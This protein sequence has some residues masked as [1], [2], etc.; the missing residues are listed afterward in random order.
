MT[1]T[2]DRDTLRLG[3]YD[4]RTSYSEQISILPPGD[5]KVTFE[6]LDE[7][8][9]FNC[10]RTS[11]IVFPDC[12]SV[13][14]NNCGAD[15]FEILANDPYCLYLDY[16]GREWLGS[17][18][19]LEDRA[20]YDDLPINC[21]VYGGLYTYEEALTI[22]PIGWR[23][24]TLPTKQE[25]QELL[26]MGSADVTISGEKTIIPGAYF[27]KDNNYWGIQNSGEPGFNVKPSGYQTP[28]GGFSHLGR[29]AYFWSATESEDPENANAM[30][31]IFSD[32]NNNVIISPNLKTNKM[33]CRCIKN[34]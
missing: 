17:N 1:L 22:C 5:Y 15:G 9:N 27:F 24:P 11:S 7:T 32:T 18:L 23:L 34:D 33:S 6:Y 10:I 8:G 3:P 19:R 2:S 14:D 4:F 28:T 31:V 21:E 16:L 13:N 26:E 20:C 29:Y 30:A 25:W 12:N